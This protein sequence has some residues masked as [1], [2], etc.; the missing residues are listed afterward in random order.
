VGQPNFLIYWQ[1]PQ[2]PVEFQFTVFLHHHGASNQHH[3]TMAHEGGMGVGTVYLYVD[4][5][6]CALQEL[7][8]SFVKWP[9]GEQLAQ[10]KEGFGDY[11]F[12]G[13]IGAANGTLFHLVEVPS[14]NG[15]YY[16]CQ[17]KYYGVRSYAT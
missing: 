13:A 6:T 11:G 15:I 10:I 9:K 1:R 12:P 8:D 17:K 14:K 3:V 2:H 16:Y 5:M 4:W 7:R